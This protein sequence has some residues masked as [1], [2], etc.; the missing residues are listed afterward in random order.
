MERLCIG[1]SIEV[2]FGAVL[3]LIG[4]EVIRRSPSRRG[5]TLLSS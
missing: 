2:V 3:L 5:G 4:M 1:E